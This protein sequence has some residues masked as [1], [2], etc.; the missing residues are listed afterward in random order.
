MYR[1]ILVLAIITSAEFQNV[2]AQDA[3]LPK[4]SVPALLTKKQNDAI[5]K[6]R[7][8]DSALNVEY[9]TRR[10]AMNNKGMKGDSG[11][12]STFKINPGSEN[13]DPTISRLPKMN[14][15]LNINHEP[16]KSEDSII[17][18]VPRA[19]D[20]EI[21]TPKLKKKMKTSKTDSTRAKHG[22]RFS[23]KNPN[24]PR[25]A[26]LNNITHAGF[27]MREGKMME[28][29]ANSFTTMNF[30]ITLVNGTYVTHD[31]IVT[32]KNG[33]KIKFKNGDFIDF[34]GRMNR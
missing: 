2:V 9:R 6:Q 25:T 14:G 27:T 17:N 21:E 22:L 30:N 3:T 18:R 5:D 7:E 24:T 23:L 29:K 20:I 11:M 13:P 26:N 8:I 4:D 10:D 16:K 19:Y 15:D 31:G 1:I 34:Y 33:S 32:K 28:V 12:R